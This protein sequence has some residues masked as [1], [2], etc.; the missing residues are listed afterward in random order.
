ML[1]WVMMA[2]VVV[3]KNTIALMFIKPISR[4]LVI[5]CG[6]NPSFQGTCRNL[7]QGYFMGRQGFSRSLLGKEWIPPTTVS[8]EMALDIGSKFIAWG[9]LTGTAGAAVYSLHRR[10]RRSK[11]KQNLAFDYAY[12]K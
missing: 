12:G 8:K 6:E 5:I 3:I 1:P 9:M 11:T 2:K 7:T 4:K 10:R